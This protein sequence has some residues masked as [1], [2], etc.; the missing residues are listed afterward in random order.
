MKEAETPRVLTNCF[1]QPTCM[2]VESFMYVLCAKR[3]F[4][5]VSELGRSI[6]VYVPITVKN[7]MSSETSNK[8]REI[9]PYNILEKF[10]LGASLLKLQT[11]FLGFRTY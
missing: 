8:R 11:S 7:N 5:E 6:L 1:V 3:A 10:Y 9:G 2:L 4:P